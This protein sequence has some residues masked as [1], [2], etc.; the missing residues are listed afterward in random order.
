M[1]VVTHEV[2]VERVAAD[3]AAVDS[4]IARDFAPGSDSS[5]FHG[6]TLISTAATDTTIPTGIRRLTR[7][8]IRAT[9]RTTDTRLLKRHP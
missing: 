2:P 6:S 9:V 3:F 1:V 5:A 8:Q 4:P 7:T